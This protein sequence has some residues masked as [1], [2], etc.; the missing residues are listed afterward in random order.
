MD[1]VSNSI[2]NTDDISRLIREETGSND[3][4]FQDAWVLVL[5]N[6]LTEPSAIRQV[7]RK[8]RKH[9]VSARITQQ[10][11]EQSL[12][13]PLGDTTLSL[14]DLLPAPEAFSDTHTAPPVPHLRPTKGHMQ[15]D[16][17][18][19]AAILSRFPG[20][21]L[22]ESVR[23]LAGL[24]PSTKTTRWQQWED[25]IIAERYSWGGTK[26]VQL[27]VS[28]TPA[29]IQSR[30][31]TLGIR[32]G[33]FRPS[34]GWL[35]AKETAEGLHMGRRVITQ[36]VTDGLLE[37]Q[38][39]RDI[40][41]FPTVFLT[42]K[43]LREFMEQHPFQYP[44]EKVEPGF[45]SLVPQWL[46]EWRPI[47][48]EQT[49]FPMGIVMLYRHIQRGDFPHRI[50]RNRRLYARPVDVQAF[51]ARPKPPR[52]HRP[53]PFGVVAYG[54]VKHYLFTDTETPADQARL[55][56]KKH[57]TIPILA[58]RKARGRPT[59]RVCLSTLKSY[60]QKGR[61]NSRPQ[62][63]E[64]P[65]PLTKP[66]LF[67]PFFRALDFPTITNRINRIHERH[68]KHR[69]PRCNA[70]DTLR[71]GCRKNIQRWLCKH[72]NKT[73]MD[74]IAAPKMQ[75]PIRLILEAWRLRASGLSLRLITSRLNAHGDTFVSPATC[76]RWLSD[77]RV[78]AKVCR[79]LKIPPP[80]LGATE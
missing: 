67:D 17:E 16:P 31:R 61:T 34:L 54:D 28:R 9:H 66:M 77:P 64:S 12:D 45:A 22:A 14:H 20:K 69:C 33:V 19:L 68:T 56:C 24:P 26:A 1:N 80:Y 15:V 4:A 76:F 71:Y 35:T 18:T 32:R 6:N 7:A 40:G 48:S 2:L 72:C 29:A 37:A 38:R 11:R 23:L 10:H 49:S 8:E 52:R 43:S 65:S 47:Q 53:Q 58:I 27:D 25:D 73:Y 5:R 79:F 57:T 63:V 55:W 51:N 44:H 75:V 70:P 13:A 42:R 46:N 59:C 74:I 39:V 21:S 30:A 62:P 36:L 78:I 60:Q 3:D 41:R 50:G